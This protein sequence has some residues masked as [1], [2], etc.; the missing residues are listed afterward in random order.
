M[1][2]L[3]Q[4]LFVTFLCVSLWSVSARAAAPAQQLANLLGQFNSLTAD[5]QQTIYDGHGRVLQTSHGNMKLLRPHSLR[6]DTLAPNR[7]LL[8]TNGDQLWIYDVDLEQVEIKPLEKAFGNQPAMLLTSSAREMQ[9]HFIVS[10]VPSGNKMR[11]FQ[12]EPKDPQADFNWIRFY[13]NGN[14]ISKMQ[15]NDKIGQLTD[16]VFSEVKRNTAVSKSDFIFAPPKGV[17]IIKDK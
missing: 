3:R 8:I 10:T 5:F 11:E 16:I 4:V 6:W 1:K 7:Q 9:Q 12:L 2:L 14:M 17:D 15:I 13:F